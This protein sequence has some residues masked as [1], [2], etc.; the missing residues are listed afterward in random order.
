MME[1]IVDELRKNNVNIDIATLSRHINYILFDY[2]DTYNAAI[3]RVNSVQLLSIFNEM[4]VSSFGHV[5]AYLA[6]VYRMNSS[7]RMVHERKNH[8]PR[9]DP[10]HFPRTTRGPHALST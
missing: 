4:N 7:Y 3:K 5:M 1:V 6:L 8:A 10:T 2:R 9:V